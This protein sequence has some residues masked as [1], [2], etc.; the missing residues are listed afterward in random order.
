MFRQLRSSSVNSCTGYGN[1]VPG[2]CHE[3]G[4]KVTNGFEL[5]LCR[6]NCSKGESDGAND[7]DL[8]AVRDSFSVGYC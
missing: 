5:I 4:R 3:T 2:L 1:S 7:L 8:E 6:Q